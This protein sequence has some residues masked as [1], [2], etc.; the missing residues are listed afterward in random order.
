[1]SIPSYSAFASAFAS[2]WRSDFATFFGY[3]PGPMPRLWAVSWLY[4]RNGI[5]RFSSRTSSSSDFAASSGRPRIAF[6][7]S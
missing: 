6:R 1:V 4:R 2:T 7:T 3:R 5:A